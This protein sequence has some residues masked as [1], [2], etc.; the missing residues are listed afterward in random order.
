[1]K[2]IPVPSVMTFL[3]MPGLLLVTQG[4]IVSYSSLDTLASN[5]SVPKQPVV[6]SYSVELDDRAQHAFREL[7]PYTST[8]YWHA[9]FQEAFAQATMTSNPPLNGTHCSITYTRWRPSG[10]AVEGVQSTD[11]SDI[12]ASLQTLGLIPMW[13][14]QHIDVTY[15]VYIGNR[16]VKK[17]Q[18]LFRR[19]RYLHILLVP[20]AWINFFTESQESMVRQTAFKF[21]QD[22]QA[23]GYL[24]DNSAPLPATKAIAPPKE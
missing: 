1:M 7:E 10:P 9:P 5:S 3:L 19:K 24:S 23:D 4:C 14:E 16:P 8:D 15:E 17:Y 12:A 21:L 11:S 2:F 13:S 22:M 18:Y 6:L 20:L